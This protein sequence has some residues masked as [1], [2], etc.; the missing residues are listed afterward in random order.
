M[1]KAGVQL[2]RFQ[3]MILAFGF[4]VF[5]LGTQQARGEENAYIIK[6]SKYSVLTTIDRLERI[7]KKR[8][9]TIFARVNH[10]ASAQTAGQSI[11]PSEVLIFGSPKMGTPLIKENPVMG[12]VLPMR[13]LSYRGP[14]GKTWIT[15]LKPEVMLKGSKVAE[16]KKIIQ[17]MTRALASMTR[18]A[19]G[20]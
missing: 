16:D 4:V 11:V 13:V 12:L 18:W 14:K 8:G 20:S 1:R 7:A 2:S 9:L 5:G 3:F 10:Q 19:S 15:Y 6:P 17:N